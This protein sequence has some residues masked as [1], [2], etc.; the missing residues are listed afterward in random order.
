MTAR[1]LDPDTNKDSK[2]EP[3]I[4][5]VNQS[6]TKEKETATVT[7][8]VAEEFANIADSGNAS[9]EN[10]ITEPVTL[11]EEPKRTKI[12]SVTLLPP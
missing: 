10:L 5:T 7:T 2:N 11:Q 6:L 9:P 12:N 8:E 3:T 1:N 4:P